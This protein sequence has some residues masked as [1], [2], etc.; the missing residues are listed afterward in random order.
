VLWQAYAVSEPRERPDV[1][2]MLLRAELKRVGHPESLGRL[3]KFAAAD[4]TDW[5]SRRTLAVE[6]QVAGR[7]DEADRQSAAC[8]RAR[9]AASAT[10]SGS[11]TTLTTRM[12]RSP[13]AAVPTTPT[14]PPPSSASPPSATGSAGTAKPWP[15]GKPSRG[16]DAARPDATPSSVRRVSRDNPGG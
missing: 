8:I 1:L 5:E 12:P 11:S 2:L 16:D 9:P 7:P 3:R 13:P 10:T 4:P 6:E 14:A 15:G